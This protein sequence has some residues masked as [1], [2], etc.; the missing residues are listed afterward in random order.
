MDY[1]SVPHCR[2]IG[3]RFLLA[4][5]K[6]N[7]QWKIGG[8]RDTTRHDA[9]RCDT[10]RREKFATSFRRNAFVDATGREQADWLAF[11][12][13]SLVLLL[14]SQHRPLPR[15]N[16]VPKLSSISA[17][18]AAENSVAEEKSSHRPSRFNCRRKRAN[19]SNI[20]SPSQP[21]E[22]HA[23]GNNSHAIY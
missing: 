16:S 9:T 15:I 23:S 2:S 3:A 12:P 18:S 10:M 17:I 20:F 11:W 21:N 22:I 7:I 14:I 19:C 6:G 1:H 8:R 5:H 13:V 4:Q